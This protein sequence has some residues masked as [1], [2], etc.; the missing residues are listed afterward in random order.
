M[1][2]DVSESVVVFPC[3]DEKLVAILHDPGDSTARLGVLFVVGGPQYRV[4]SHRQFVLM[5]RMIAAVGYP[6][7]RFDYRGMGDSSGASRTFD[8]VDQDIRAAID[9][10]LIE[11]PSLQTVVILGLCDAASAALMYCTADA[12][13]R[14]LVLINPWARTEGGNA[15]VV[16]R[17]YYL[18]RLAQRSFWI[19][20]FSGAFRLRVALREF[21]GS[22]RHAMHR[23]AKQ[24]DATTRNFL[25]RMGDGAAAFR[26]PTLLLLSDHDLTAK[27][28]ES[29][30]RSSPSWTRWL[31][32]DSLTQIRLHDADHTFSASWTL[33]EASSH[34]LKWLGSLKPG[35][36]T[37]V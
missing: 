29:Y 4:G 3:D 16:M 20:A 24:S 37:N 36:G 2:V 17:H 33:V 6:V 26:Q 10:F 31:A 13:V 15:R 8:C 22:L 34:I 35:H 21:L 9:A 23:G 12:R 1:R 5:A 14:G 19:K 11:I 25:L 7:L 28:F 18:T 32:S 27:E 30:C